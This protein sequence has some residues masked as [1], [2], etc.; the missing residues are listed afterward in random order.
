LR[1]FIEKTIYNAPFGILIT[2]DDNVIA[3][4]QRIVTM[5]LSSFLLLR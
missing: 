3:D 4:D 5:P 2:L 1:S